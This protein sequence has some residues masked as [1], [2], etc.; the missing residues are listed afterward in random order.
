MSNEFNELVE[1]NKIISKR[2]TAMFSRFICNNKKIDQSFR[3]MAKE[4]PGFIELSDQIKSNMESYLEL[5]QDQI[6]D[7][8]LNGFESFFSNILN[9]SS[10]VNYDQIARDY[11]NKINQE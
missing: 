3:S 7:A 10:Q 11:I 4:S 5:A 9:L 1:E 2:V 8:D 6:L